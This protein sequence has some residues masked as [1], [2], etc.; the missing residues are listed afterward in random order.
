[1]AKNFA[2]IFTSTGDSIA[3]EQKIFVKEESSKG[4]LITPLGTDSLLPEGGTSV[5]FSQTKRS[6]TVKSGR[7]NTTF[8]KDKTLTEWTINSLVHIDTT[9][10]APAAAEVDQSYKT[11]MK[12][13]LGNESLV[14]G[15][16]YTP[17]TPDITFSLFE[18]GDVMAKQSPGA[19]VQGATVNLPGDGDSNYEFRGN[20]KTT[21]NVGLGRSVTDNDAGNT[22]T[23]DVLTDANR[24]PVGAFVMLIESDGV[25]RS[26]DTPDGSPRTVT[27]RDPGAGTVT[28]SGAVFADA[29]GASSTVY[30]T[31]YE[32]ATVTVIND[33]ITGLVGSIVIDNL[34]SLNC[35]RNATL[36]IENNHNLYD[37]CFGEEGLAGPL[38]AAGGRVDIT[39]EMELLLNKE[40]VTY[41]D[42]KK[43][44]TSDDVD[45]VL[46]DSAGR[47]LKVDLPKVI[48]D[49][50]AIEI[51]E[52]GNVPVTMNGMSFQ[53][54]L[55]AE[56]ELVISYI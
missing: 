9:L 49:F 8:L 18:N 5:N 14:G 11:L 3:L 17:T 6:S 30:L 43:T 31:Y 16:I 12:S 20:A 54:A 41:L 13:L 52:S 34:S 40:F 47:H 51:P 2:N 26:A 33:P 28:L 46:G 25:T 42:G 39:L 50:P 4:V 36:T 32:P 27:A 24:F 29:D 55:E 53:T 37:N 35:V 48:Y 22:V 19:F 45:I 1:M 56:D 15:A 44:F 23:L 7:H 10:G 21:L 38:F